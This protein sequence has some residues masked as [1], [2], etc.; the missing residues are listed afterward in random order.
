MNKQE[1]RKARASIRA[2]GLTA[3]QWL[4]PAHACAML[5]LERSKPDWMASRAWFARL[6]ADRIQGHPVDIVPCGLERMRRSRLAS[7]EALRLARRQAR[8]IPQATRT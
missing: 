4:K 1:Y 8:Y 7:V 5:A 3:L 6:T 2:N